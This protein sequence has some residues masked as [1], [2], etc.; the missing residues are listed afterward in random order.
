MYMT[1]DLITRS[2]V[3]FVSNEENI[4]CLMTYN[5]SCYIHS[6]ALSES[7]VTYYIVQVLH[8]IDQCLI[9]TCTV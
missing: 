4:N 7:I 6:N 8:R 5:C 2:Y 9:F 3:Y 1:S